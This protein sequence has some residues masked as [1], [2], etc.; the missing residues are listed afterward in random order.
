VSLPA[1]SMRQLFDLG[2]RG[3]SALALGAVA[4]LVRFPFM[5]GTHNARPG[6]DDV[7][8]LQMSSL[9]LHQRRF[10]LDFYT[11][12]YPAFEAVLR[13][14]PGRAEDTITVTQH[15]IGVAIVV[16]IVL[17]G[18]RWFGPPAALAA[19]LLSALTPQLVV[20]EHTLLP[21]FLFGA[22]AFAGALVLG[23]ALRREPAATRPLIAVGIVFGLAAWVKPA[24]EFLLLAAPLAALLATRSLRGALRPTAVVT[25][26]LVV[27]IAPWLVR[28]AIDWGQLGMSTQDGQTLFS[29]VFE[30]DRLPIPGDSPYTALARQVRARSDA[31]RDTR[32]NYDFNHA[33]RDQRGLGFQEA[34]HVQREMSWTAIGR[35]P[36]AYVTG[37]GRELVNELGQ[38]D[39]FERDQEVLHQLAPRGAIVEGAVRATWSVARALVDVWWVLSLNALAGLLLVAVGPPE[40]RA[41]AAALLAVWFSV[42]LGTAM[43]H[44]YLWRYSM[45]VAP[46]A[47]LLG[48]AGVA[49]IAGWLWPRVRTTLPLRHRAPAG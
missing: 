1:A 16:A 15:L 23:G 30:N 13:L 49:L 4:F 3:Y 22:L 20:H 46:V 35:H 11:P 47:W 43:F 2:A 39:D 34:I 29:R 8:Y 28:N 6:K 27:T 32:F 33:L 18:W 31:A 48:T 25:L 7:G 24:G 41:A 45:Q 42:V 37:T 12:G 38:L 9:L 21:D 14:L 40:R 19:G 26:T 5:L 17:V 10:E 36:L 44:G